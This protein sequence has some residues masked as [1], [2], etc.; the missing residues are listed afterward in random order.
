MVK[1]FGLSDLGKSGQLGQVVILRVE[2]WSRYIIMNPAVI[3]ITG[4]RAMPWYIGVVTK[5]CS[6][7]VQVRKNSVRREGEGW[8]AWQK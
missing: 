8:V 1:T 4:G 7:A 2:Y 3:G 6:S 5:G